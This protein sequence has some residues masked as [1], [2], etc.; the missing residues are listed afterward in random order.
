M[1]KTCALISVLAPA[2]LLTACGA[3]SSAEAEVQADGVRI[4]V[5]CDVPAD[6]NIKWGEFERQEKLGGETGQTEYDER[7]RRDKDELTL[8][9]VVKPAEDAEGSCTSKVLDYTDQV[10]TEHTGDNEFT[11]TVQVSKPA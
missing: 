8:T 10:L 1:K 6:L 3:E 4:Q 5:S 7:F 11:H 2:L 9:M